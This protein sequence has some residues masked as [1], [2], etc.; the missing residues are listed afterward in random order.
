M[1]Q[2]LLTRKSLVVIGLNSGTSA[3]GLDLTAV[4]IAP[5]RPRFGGRLL[6]GKTVPYPRAIQTRLTDAINDR[7]DSIDELVR[8]DRKLGR[9][10]GEQARQFAE[11][12]RAKGIKPLLIAS[13][14]QTVRH[15]P[16]KVII[17][18]KKESGTLQLGHPESVAHRTGL[19]TVADF[20]QADVASG[21]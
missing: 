9:F 8:L 18:K 20:R 2:K 6:A 16:G 15:L 7:I 12:M 21:G 13:H 10:F 5:S 17:G 4:R 19:V 11:F 1:L 3:D 14:G